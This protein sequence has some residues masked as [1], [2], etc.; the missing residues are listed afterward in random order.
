MSPP[1][2]S[3]TELAKQITAIRSRKNEI[4]DLPQKVQD[5]HGDLVKL[6][7]TGGIVGFVGTLGASFVV[8]ETI[9][10][11]K[12]WDNRDKI[13]NALGET[14][15]KLE[16]MDPGLEVPVTFLKYA[17]E[18]R[19][20][21][22]DIDNASS[23]Y[24]ETE[25]MGEW[26][27]DAAKR[28]RALRIRQEKAFPAMSTLCE[29]IALNLESVAVAEL[30]LYTDLATAAQELVEKVTALT[31]SYVG[32]FF[33]LPWGPISASGDLATAV[34]ASNTFI[35]DISTAVATSAQANIIASNRI[36]QDASVQAGIP[37]NHWPPGVVESYGIGKD[38]ITAA[39]GDASTRDNDKSDWTL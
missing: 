29:N 10:I 13:N 17:D 22:G 37:N 16:E 4:G 28:Y 6:V 27:G 20:I 19:N 35:L 32:S 38:G 1:A 11:P 30:E 18:W 15:N 9:V 2:S 7:R 24:G 34:Q 36:A 31:G 8:D 39:L 23:T 3:Q 12:I 25:L 21:K 26:E 5:W 33:N 14:W